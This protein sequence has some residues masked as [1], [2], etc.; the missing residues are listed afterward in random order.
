MA[1]K[2]LVTTEK[3]VGRPVESNPRSV[4]LKIKV[5]EEE[6]KKIE[7]LAKKME[8]TKSRLIR[9]LLLGGLD[10][11]VFLNK[12]GILPLVKNLRDLKDKLSG[13]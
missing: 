2:E 10:D 8:M 6:A 7:E 9:N 13:V 11:A 12:I 1:E 5:T 3:T 4:Q